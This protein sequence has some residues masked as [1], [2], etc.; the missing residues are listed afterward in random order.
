MTENPST[1]VES[2]D[3]KY[4]QLIKARIHEWAAG[5]P[6]EVGGVDNG[7]TPYE[8]LLSA[9]GPVLRSLSKCMQRARG[10]RWKR[11]MPR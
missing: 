1:T 11:C 4:A 2:S 3:G 8:L 7:P 6:T 5:E 9:L 10:G